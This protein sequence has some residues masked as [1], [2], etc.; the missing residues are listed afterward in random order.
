MGK[1]RTGLEHLARQKMSEKKPPPALRDLDNKL[2]EARA[3]RESKDRGAGARTGGMA[4][5]GLA[6]RLGLDFIAG[7]VVGVGIG[8][9][10]D[11]E[12]GVSQLV[13]V[14]LRE[15]QRLRAIA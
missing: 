10:L 13:S 4:G 12:R 14:D 3:R 11:A 6:I 7:V 5:L 9:L 15:A 1:P 8:L 2:R